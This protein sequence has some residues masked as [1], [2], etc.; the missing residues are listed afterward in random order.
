MLWPPADCEHSVL[1]TPAQLKTAR[2]N[3]YA[4]MQLTDAQGRE[5]DEPQQ[6]FPQA[7]FWCP[8]AAHRSHPSRFYCAAREM[9]QS[10]SMGATP[11]ACGCGGLRPGTAAPRWW[12]RRKGSPRP[13]LAASSSLCTVTSCCS[14]RSTAACARMHT[15]NPSSLF[16]SLNVAAAAA[17][18]L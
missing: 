2:H 12:E 7:C 10:R 13:L 14:N 5:V 16:L 1:S 3:F 4:Q 9:I 15:I 17:S 11:L 18:P 8:D 6:T